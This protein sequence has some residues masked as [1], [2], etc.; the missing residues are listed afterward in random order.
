VTASA[1]RFQ[2]VVVPGRFAVCRL[3]PERAVPDWAAGTAFVS[4]TRTDDELSIVCEAHRV[5][6]GTVCE[7]EYAALRV[8]GTLAPDLVGVLLA[9]AGPLADARVSIL[10]IGT[11]DTDYVL[12]RASDLPRAVAAL[13]SAGHSVT[14]D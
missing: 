5:P 7:R 6:D 2:L 4:I 3:S 13:R 9:L 8:A 1:H 11:Y 10:A 14:G 12:V